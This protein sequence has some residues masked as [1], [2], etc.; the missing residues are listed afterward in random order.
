M[1]FILHKIIL[2]AIMACY[3]PGKG[4]GALNKILNAFNLSQ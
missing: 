4:G 3:V 1:N 2:Y